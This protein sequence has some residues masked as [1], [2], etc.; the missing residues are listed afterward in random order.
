ML[1]ACGG[2]PVEEVLPPLPKPVEA[3][4]R[5]AAESREV[6]E[7]SI[8]LVGEVRG[9]IQ[10][11]GCPTVPYGGFARR[12]VFLDQFQAEKAPLFQLDAGEPMPML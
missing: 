12:E 2:E 1:G 6:R 3:L 5:Q 9:E 7:L 11:C 4:D 8:A 10:P